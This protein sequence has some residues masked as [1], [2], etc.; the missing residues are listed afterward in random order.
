MN[1]SNFTVSGLTNQQDPLA[2]YFETSEAVV[3][4]HS[5][6]PLVVN[7][8]ENIDAVNY[9]M[10]NDRLMVL[11]PELPADDVLQDIKPDSSFDY[12]LFNELRLSAV[13]VL[14][15]IVKRLT[16]PDGTMRIVVRGLKRVTCTS[17]LSDDVVKMRYTPVIENVA[18]N[19]D[20]DIRGAQDAVINGFRK[21]SA[22]SPAYNDDNVNAVSSAST[23]VRSADILADILNIAFAEKLVVLIHSK[24]KERLALLS[25]WINREIETSRIGMKIQSQVHESMSQQQR[26]YFLKEQ[27]KTIKKELGEDTRNPDLIELDRRR[28]TVKVPDYVNAV[29]ER[30]LGRLE[31]IPTASPEYHIYYLYLNWLLDIPWYV[32]SEDNLDCKVAEKILNRDHF[33]L[34]DVKKRILEFLSVMQL[35]GDNPDKKAP[36]LC[37]IG[38][39]GVGKTSLGQS[40]AE[41]MNRK[42]IRFSLGGMRDEAEIRGHRRTYVGAMPGRIV[43]NLK[44]IGTNNPV[45]MLDEIDKLAHDFRGDPA[46]A[47]LEVLDPEQN[48]SFNDN[49]LEVGLDLSKIFF[50]ATANQEENIPGPLRD[51]MEII[52]LSGY[53]AIEKHQISKKYIVPRQIKACGLNAKLVKFKASALEEIITFYTMEAGVRTL[54]QVIGR[55]CRRIAQKIVAGEI[56]IDKDVKVDSAMVQE[57]LGPRK[58]LPDNESETPVPGRAVG[59]A[60]NGAGGAILPIE[61]TMLPGG[62]G[63]LKLTGSL[64]KVMTESAEIAFSLVRSVSKDLGIE[65]T[66][67]TEN[68]FH[69][70]VPD[71]ST[72]KDGP[73]AGV[74]LTMALISLLTNKPLRKQLSMTGEITLHGKVTAVGGI[75]EKC[76]SAL[77]AGIRKIMMPEQNRKDYF[78]LPSEVKDKVEFHFVNNFKEAMAF[79]FG[80]K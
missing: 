46:A 60:W 80:E 62:K 75:R 35:R 68:D 7:T 56:A 12:F 67:F 77:R 49:Y 17:I 42:F 61:V 65:P 71:G 55:V 32:S 74:T 11:F 2:A 38:P 54:E 14:V 13:G 76:V 79:A 52:R 48:V 40:I 4:P 3:F 24:I 28:Q 9:A 64:G 5:L 18:D 34:E 33:G 44:R 22:I 23:P 1:E 70:H 31:M 36:I 20:P 10:Q 63:N 8:S 45:F 58:Y 19:K 43:Q 66:V 41:A 69:I 59:M 57:L 21:L 15:R 39:P 27:L 26:E 25:I 50:I 6:T 72:P 16:F 47:M 78:E 53:T 51:R 29:I 30:E 37:L 73:S